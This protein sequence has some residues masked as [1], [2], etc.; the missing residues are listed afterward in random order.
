MA[1][2]SAATTMMAFAVFAGCSAPD[3]GRE[4]ER[5]FGPDPLPV[6]LWV[7]E[8]DQLLDSTAQWT[9]KVELADLDGDG[10]L[11]L[12]FANG[13]DYS[14]PG[15]PELNR[16]FLN[17]GP[18]QRFEEH[19][20]AVFGTTPDLTRV[21]KA[22]DVDGDG[23]VDV[24]VGNTYQ[25][26][27]RLFM[28][29]G[30]GQFVERTA[31]HLPRLRLSIGDAEFGD[32]DADG[33]LDL[34]LAEWGAGNNMTNAGGRTRLWL[35]DGTG[36]FRDL[37]SARMPE[38]LVHFSWD[39]E[40]VDVDNDYDLDMLVSCKRCAGS[41]LFRNDGA[42]TFVED[43]RGIPQ[44]TNNYEFEA[45]D[46]DGDGFLDL[47]TI[48]DGEIV[49]ESSSSRREHVFRN[50][51]EG[52]FR[53]AT[54][55]WWPDSENIGED[56]NI[57]AFLDFD[58]DGD[59]DFIIGSLSGADR[60]LINDGAGHLRN[61]NDVFVGDETPG[62]LG[63]AIGDLDGDGRIDVVQ[64]QGEHPTAVQERISMGRG[65]APDTADPVVTMVSAV[66]STE[67]I[68]IRARIHD[69]KSPTL[70]TEWRRVEVEWVSNG[71]Q[72]RTPLTWYGEFLWRVVLPTD[73]AGM[74][75]CAEDASGNET[76][77]GLPGAS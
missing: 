46:L 16:S 50:N 34:V 29:T 60:L 38:T 76:C 71:E 35:N 68:L 30:G 67:G 53:D 4:A 19:T 28:G 11:D 37:T 62:T 36:R 40:F 33:D 2:R 44:Y 5:S 14:E 8:T 39:L 47:V 17:R 23:N 18:G 13:G 20:E 15:D 42:G 12:L 52:R 10:R 59:A 49:G 45:M 70:S 31:T 55:G 7:D 48:N 21:V 6:A 27:S 32:V 41:K 57:V 24:F 66:T 63:M 22:R 72:V 51:G 56:D 58:S 75:I 64:A 1:V 73:A 43:T 65:L 61:A 9:N 3:G 69:R 74:R 54:D 25:T 77:Q 26:P